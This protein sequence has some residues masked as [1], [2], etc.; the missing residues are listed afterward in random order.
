MRH[1]IM[2]M[3]SDEGSEHREALEIDLTD[4]QVGNLKVGQKIV[5]TIKG[6]VGMIGVPPEG[7]SKHSPAFLG[8]RVGSKEVKGTNMFEELAAD[9]EEEEEG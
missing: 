9:D 5:V 4:E 7:S 1:A 6:S 3:S 8:I 2:E